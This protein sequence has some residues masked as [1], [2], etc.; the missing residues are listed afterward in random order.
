MNNIISIDFWKRSPL[1]VD[2]V[3]K[4]KIEAKDQIILSLKDKKKIL[5]AE[6]YKDIVD[7]LIKD[8]DI[9]AN[10]RCF[11]YEDNPEDYSISFFINLHFD[12]MTYFA[13]KGQ[14]NKT[15]NFD[16][17]LHYFDKYLQ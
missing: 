6:E 4:L 16:I 3:L 5:T 7:H 13:V 12:N 9:F 11:N 10:D 1:S 14:K 17:L 2:E 8:I 15:K